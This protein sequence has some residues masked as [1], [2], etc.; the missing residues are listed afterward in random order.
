MADLQ[1]FKCKYCGGR[2]I[3]DSA[4]QNM[5]CQFCDS[6]FQLSDFQNEEGETDAQSSES[7]DMGGFSME[8]DS[9]GADETKGMNV[10]VCQ[11]CGGE[12]I[13]DETLGSSKCPYCDNNIVMKEQ[14]K[15][16]LKPELIIPFKLDKNAAKKKYLDHL[17][18]K[19][20]LP[21]VFKDQNHID[22]IKGVYVP[23]W[24]YDA[25]VDAHISYEA[26]KEKNW[27]DNNYTYKETSYFDVKRDGG[28]SFDKI[29]ADAS[30]KMPDDLMESIEPYDIKGAVPFS[31]AYLAGYLADK[32]DV[33]ADTYTEHIQERITSSTLSHFRETVKGYDSVSIRHKN[34]RIS[35]GETHY[36]MYPVWLL[37]TTW[38][39]QKF[40]FAMN[41]QTG[42]FVGNLPL[43]KGAYWKCFATLAAVFSALAC[44]VGYFLK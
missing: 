19:K 8:G 4:T 12:I 20:F 14:F 37:N 15:G 31:T 26:T 34:I 22:E 40:T 23:F 27:S 43:D 36:A 42:K 38:N 5:K 29:P 32:Y 16:D 21:K 9:W 28:L 39:G 2:V 17:N 24:L 7:G 18:S 41:G 35:K 10:Y 13:A 33:E 1:D 44:L 25:S 6:V 30:S 11:S 3:F